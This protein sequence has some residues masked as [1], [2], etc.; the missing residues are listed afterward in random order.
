MTLLFPP[1][2]EVG[3]PLLSDGG[4]SQ[5]PQAAGTNAR[6][7]GVKKKGQFQNLQ[8]KFVVIKPGDA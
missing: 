8:V 1:K 7:P 6:T 4:L 5:Q 2:D 3:N